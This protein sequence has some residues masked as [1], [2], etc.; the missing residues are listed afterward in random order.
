M[1]ISVSGSFC[2]QWISSLEHIHLWSSNK[3][4]DFLKNGASVGEGAQAIWW[5]TTVGLVPY[6]FNDWLMW[7]IQWPN[8][9]SDCLHATVPGHCLGALVSVVHW[10]PCPIENEPYRPYSGISKPRR[11]ALRHLCLFCEALTISLCSGI[12]HFYRLAGSG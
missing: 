5:A 6:T 10:C 1:R 9:L 2:H 12:D 8:I 3:M 7:L 4:F 11:L